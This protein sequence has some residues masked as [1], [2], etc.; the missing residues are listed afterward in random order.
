M[1]EEK[2]RELVYT[3]PLREAYK[4]SIRKRTPY[5]ARAIRAFLLQHTKAETVKLG[6]HL[7]EV[8]W[9]R[10]RKKPPRRVRVK[11]VRDGSV[12]KAELF[13][14]VYEDFKPLP[15]Q[16]KK[17]MRE[18]LAERLGPKAA[19]KQEEEQLAE[20]KKEP[21]KAVKVEEQQMAEK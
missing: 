2:E 9:E 8:V 18:R 15:K 5:A 19:K 21:E 11:V 16:E 14:F 13:G 1:A 20:G 6:K 4:K 7:N 10:G 3:I 17:G 12:A